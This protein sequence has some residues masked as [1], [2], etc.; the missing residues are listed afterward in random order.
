M[1]AARFY[2]GLNRC[3]RS[4]RSI[5]SLLCALRS[6]ETF[7][8]Y[9]CIA[10]YVSLRSSSLFLSFFPW[11]IIKIF[12]SIQFFFYIRCSCWLFERTAFMQQFGSL[13][14]MSQLCRENVRK[15]VDANNYNGHNHEDTIQNIHSAVQHLCHNE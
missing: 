11:E 9:K 14:F 15:E 6:P 4:F 10:V 13:L 8:T 12:L 7:S 5:V 1:P 2:Y 3:C